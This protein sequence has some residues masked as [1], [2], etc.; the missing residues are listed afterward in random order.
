VYREL[1]IIWNK[2]TVGYFDAGCIISAFV[3][4]YLGKPTK[5]PVRLTSSSNRNS[6][7]LP[8]GYN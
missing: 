5:I 6:K 4:S 1:E 3:R 8:L 7:H 2:E